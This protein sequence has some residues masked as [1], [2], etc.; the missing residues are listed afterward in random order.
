MMTREL[1]G[2]HVLSITIGAFSVIIGVNIF[3]AYNAVHSFPGLEVS[4]SYVASQEF[5]RLRT[6]QVALGWRV[7]PRYADGQLSFRILGMDGL[8]AQIAHFSALIGRTTMARED[9]TPVFRRVNGAYVTDL[10]L[11]PGAWLVHLEAVAT[12]GTPFRQRIDLFV[13]G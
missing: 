5:D 12:D 2:K 13:R 1:T 11:A 3:M 4:N 10:D 9:V 6:A 8:P 7:E